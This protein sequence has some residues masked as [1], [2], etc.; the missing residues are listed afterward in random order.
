VTR[1]G[2]LE[3]DSAK[4]SWVTLTDTWMSALTLWLP[5][6]NSSSLTRCDQLFGRPIIAEVCSLE[7]H[8]P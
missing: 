4:G 1:A 7:D 6:R 2:A 5:A 8:V 3:S